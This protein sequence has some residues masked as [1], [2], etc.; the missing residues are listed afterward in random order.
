LLVMA[1]FYG[2]LAGQR[3]QVRWLY[4]SLLLTDWAIAQEF[5]SHRWDLP[6]VQAC[7]V[8]LS[9][10]SITW[11]EPACQSTSG[12]SLRHNIRLL[13]AGMIGGSAL[14]IYFQPGIIPGIVGI[15]GIFLGLGLRIRAFLY[16]G[17]L[18]FLAIAFYQLVILVFTYPELKWVIGFLIGILFIWTAASFETRRSQ[19]TTI[20]QN[21]LEEFEA[22]Q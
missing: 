15:T 22:W 1:S 8:G 11:F 20:L 14:A 17:T 12:R 6:F 21:W 9:I 13:G 10:L 19:F 16:V 2:W 5:A 7:L 4:G 3:Q 18:T